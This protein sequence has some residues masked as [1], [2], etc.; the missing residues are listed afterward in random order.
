[1]L[2]THVVKWHEYITINSYYLALTM[3]SQTLVPLVLPLLVQQFVGET[4]KATYIGTLRL[5]GLMAALL[6][7]A[8]WGML[9][10]RATLGW[11]RRRPFIFGG[12]AGSIAFILA[13]GLTAGLSGMSGFWALFVGY[14][15]LQVCNNAAHSAVQGFIP[16]LIP[17]EK[18]GL[19]SGIKTL[20][21]V[22][23][24]MILVAVL[25]AAPIGDQQLWIGLGILSVFVLL[26]LGLALLTREIPLPKKP[27]PFNWRPLLRLLLMT[28][29]FTLIILSM[30]AGVTLLGDLLSGVAAVRVLILAMGS[31]GLFAMVLAVALGVWL[32][33]RIGIGAAQLAHHRAFAWWVM[34]RLA[35]LVP[36]FSIS[37]FAL[38]F[39][40]G[41]FGLVDEAAAEPVAQMMMFVGVFVLLAAL[42]SGWL[43]DRFGCKCIIALSAV[44]AATGALLLLLASNLTLVYAAACLIGI[45]MG[46]FYSANWALG[47]GL[48]PQAEAGRF[49]GISNLAGAGAGAVGAY[50]GGPIADFF[51]AN[52]PETPGLGY[53]VVFT[54]YALLFLLSLVPLA[55]IV[56]QK[57]RP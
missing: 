50:I 25:I 44:I 5:W 24:P 7:Q 22:P 14:L 48:V 28:T 31:F 1:M 3:I 26:S 12:A 10:D 9:S 19:A 2:Q 11:G 27:V 49:L 30:G 38:Y 13:I 42:P 47:V 17:L 43:S 46:F 6:S 29:A 45:A 8:L 18:Q 39:L 33:V 51:T 4:S 16:D 23:I 53:V 20:L 35:F 55:R 15:L 54:I 40:Q 52:V 56:D 41:R 32:S 21:E 36:A 34:N 37:G 57:H